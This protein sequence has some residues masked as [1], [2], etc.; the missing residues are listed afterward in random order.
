MTAQTWTSLKQTVAIALTQAVTPY[1]SFPANFDAQFPQATSYAENRIHR[2]IPM[3][4]VR[5]SETVAAATASGDR[6]IDLNDFSAVPL[7][8]EQVALVTPSG[9]TTGTLV[10]YDSVSLDFINRT[11]PIQADTEAPSFTWQG[12]RYFAMSDFE[13]VVLSPTPDAA[14]AVALVG[15]FPPVPISEGNL[16]TYL[17]TYYPELLEAGCLVFLAGALTRN[18]GSQADEPKLAMSWEMQFRSLLDAARDEERRRRGLAPD[19]PAGR[20]AA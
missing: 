11:W 14:Y 4:A 9:G 2:E 1:T 10:P 7:V 8:V 6:S 5:R 13:T 20:A 18:F 19:M 15:L 16:T 12:G 3:L 17:S